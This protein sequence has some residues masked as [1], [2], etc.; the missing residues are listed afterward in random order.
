M[1]PAL[2]VIRQMTDGE[3]TEDTLGTLI[4]ETFNEPILSPSDNIGK[5]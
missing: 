1:C 5:G 3:S 4:F 2:N